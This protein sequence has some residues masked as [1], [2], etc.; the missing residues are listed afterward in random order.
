MLRPSPH[1]AWMRADRLVVRSLFRSRPWLLGASALAAVAGST[2]AVAQSRDPVAVVERVTGKSAGVAE[3]DYI[4]TGQVIRLGKQDTLVVSYLRACV[5]ETI[6]GG[7][8]RIGTDGS[9]VTNGDVKRQSF[10]CDAGRLRLRPQQASASGVMVFRGGPSREAQAEI[11]IFARA[12]VIDGI[13][14]G[15]LLIERSD[16][17]ADRLVINVTPA[18]LKRRTLDLAPLGVTLDA[19]GRYVLTAGDRQLIFSVS[20]EATSADGPLLRRLVRL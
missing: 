20:P 13:G 15:T 16:R 3:M 7:T 18:M 1:G 19:G 14:A 10:T 11:T 8:V 2:G 12:P 4:A 9:E 17:A 5:R 6:Q